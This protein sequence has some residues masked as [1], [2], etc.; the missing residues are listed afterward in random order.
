MG[1]KLWTIPCCYKLR[2]SK[3]ITHSPRLR[4]DFGSCIPVGGKRDHGEASCSP[5]RGG[6]VWR[7]YFYTRDAEQLHKALKLLQQPAFSLNT[8]ST[9]EHRGS[10]LSPAFF[11]KVCSPKTSMLGKKQQTLVERSQLSQSRHCGGK[12][13]SE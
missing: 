11:C 5:G 13:A 9:Q 7:F 3:T 6:G 1:K 8:P 2:R 10:T 4:Q 12:L